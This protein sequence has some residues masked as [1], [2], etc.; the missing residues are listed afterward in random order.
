MKPSKIYIL[1]ITCLL[2][3]LLL[4][5]V[6]PKDGIRISDKFILKFTTLEE[7]FT[8][9]FMVDISEILKTNSVEDDTL[10]FSEIQ[11]L[12]SAYIDSVLVYYKPLEIYVDSVSQFLEFPAGNDSVLNPIFEILS[13]IKNT[14]DLIRILHYG[15]SQIEVDRMTSY[16]RYKLQSEFGGSG[17]GFL[18]AVQTFDFQQPM[19][20]TS[21]SNWFR[22]TIN[23]VKDSII[24]HQRF[25]ILG[26]FCKFTP[27]IA[28]DTLNVD[29]NKT[30]VKIFDKNI[31][32]EI[33]KIKYTAWLNFEHSPIVYSNVRI[34]NQCRMFYG[35]NTEKFTMKV[36]DGQTIISD[37]LYQ[38]T[39]LL[40]IKSITLQKTPQNLKFEF[41]GSDSPEIYGF[42]F[43]SFRGV[44]VDNIPLRGSSGL[45]F[46]NLDFALLQ[47]MYNSLNVKL[48]ILQ[49][50]GNRVTFEADKIKSYKN[51][52]KWQLN[53]LHKIVPNVPIIVIGPGDM[54]EKE[55]DEYLTHKNLIPVRDALREAALES[56]CVFWDMYQAMGG[57]N[58]MPSWVF[59]EPALAEKDFIHFTPNGALIV[60]KMFYNALMFE[61]NKY[62]VSK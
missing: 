58:S 30:D 44:A 7:F 15:D 17:P 8:P 36:S 52:F 31:L 54:S 25:G 26:T 12:D 39:N 40:T 27:F 53:L 11:L 42:A 6:F 47:Q 32:P 5:A 61:Y 2:S 16:I 24:Y 34:F 48:I 13:K 4:M 62:L 10:N 21:S 38:P 29:T 20:Q 49:F 57:E 33:E 55:K 37:E 43:D 18:P 45:I 9:K 1:L 22:Y 41:S 50:G 46:G 56:N 28:L 59:S 3:L 14:N 19:I 51:V 60:S 23:P 35:Y